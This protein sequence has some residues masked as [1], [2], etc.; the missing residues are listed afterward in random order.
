MGARDGGV[1]GQVLKV[2]I[3]KQLVENARPTVELAI[4]VVGSAAAIFLPTGQGSLH[5]WT[6]SIRLRLRYNAKDSR[7]GCRG[8]EGEMMRLIRMA[9]FFAVVFGGAVASSMAADVCGPSAQ[10]GTLIAR[11]SATPSRAG[12]CAGATAAST[13]CCSGQLCQG[14]NPRGCCVNEQGRCLCNQQPAPL[15]GS[16]S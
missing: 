10:Q 15:C 11:F 5:R 6:A 3:F 8:K 13:N 4:L 12:T 9:V 2:W 16:S 14:N 7:L 1:D